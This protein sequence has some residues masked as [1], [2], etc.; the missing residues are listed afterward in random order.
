MSFSFY[1]HISFYG[2]FFSVSKTDKLVTGMMVTGNWYDGMV[3]YDDNSKL[4]HDNK[5][6]N[7]SFV[8]LTT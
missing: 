4:L 8:S 6:V 2:K 1:L 7:L 5:A 3:Y